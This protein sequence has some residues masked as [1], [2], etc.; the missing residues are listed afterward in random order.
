MTYKI[1]CTV[2]EYLVIFGA[3]LF[4]CALVAVELDER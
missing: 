1:F 2:A 4:A 3:V